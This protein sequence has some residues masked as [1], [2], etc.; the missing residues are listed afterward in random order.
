[1]KNERGQSFIELLIAMGIFVALMSAVTFLV[2]NSHISNRIGQ[3]ITLADYLAQEGLEA[4]KS[5]RDNNWDDLTDGSH[6]IDIFDDRWI[7]QG[8]ENDL[9]D[10]LNDGKRS[11]VVE[12]K[13]SD[14]KKIISSV[15]WKFTGGRIQ[16]V[17]LVSYLTNWQKETSGI[18]V[19]FSS[20][21]YSVLESAGIFTAEVNLSEAY[22]GEITVRYRTENGS[23]VSP[24]DYLKADDILVFDPGVISQTFDIE[25]VDNLLEESDKYFSLI[26]YG[27]QNAMLGSPSMATIVIIDDDGPPQGCWG[28]GGECDLLCHYT[29]YG[30]PTAA[31]REPIPPCNRECNPARDIFVNP[32]G[33][34]RDDG[35]DNCYKMIDSTTGYTECIQRE[36]CEG[37]C[38]GICTPCEEIIDPRECEQQEGCRGFNVPGGGFRCL[39][40]CVVCGE[41]PDE[42]NCS[43][44][45]GCWWDATAWYWELA[46][47]QSGYFN[48]VTC[49][50]YEE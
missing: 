41:F 28:T 42:G 50:W 19:F 26:L 8:T 11:I 17:E 43:N 5:I 44:Q 47:P 36:S 49:E 21:E 4:A 9:S 39:G 40:R 34:C 35:T 14:V 22:E 13:S 25:I 7:F 1:M 20:S 32:S 33:A 2:L 30:I 45:L 16:K 10:K 29:D 15:E 12:T 31:Y 24:D 37:R 46:S 18:T 6:G 27:P 38:E 48:Y 3:E 23:A